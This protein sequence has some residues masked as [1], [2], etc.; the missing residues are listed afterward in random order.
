MPE[1]S[2]FEPVTLVQQGT[3]KRRT[4][5]GEFREKAIKQECEGKQAR[6]VEWPTVI[7]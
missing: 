3:K 5:D 1:N 7:A 4:P 6:K 2:L